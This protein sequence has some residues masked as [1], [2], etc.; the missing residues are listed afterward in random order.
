MNHGQLET[1]AEKKREQCITQWMVDYRHETGG[2]DP[3]FILDAL[4]LLI[5]CRHTLKM[6]YVYSWFLDQAV[7]NK[8]ASKGAAPSGTPAASS[9]LQTRLQLLKRKAKKHEHQ[10]S[11][12]MLKTQQELFNFQQ[13]SLE[14]TTEEL[15]HLIFSFAKQ[16]SE[17]MIVTKA[18][19]LKNLTAV[20]RQYLQN[21]VSGF[22][23]MAEDMSD[24]DE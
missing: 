3:T 22:E 6:T 11:S 17:S 21:L 23:D 9:N 14:G 24:D 19:E 13:A 15:G 12:E 18:Q 2:L 7:T 16:G 5:R 10:A 20:T 8:G 4:E 1:D